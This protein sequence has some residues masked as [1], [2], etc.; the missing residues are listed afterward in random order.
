MSRVP[1]PGCTVLEGQPHRPGCPQHPG[2]YTG[3][4]RPLIDKVVALIREHIA[5]KHLCAELAR[6][7]IEL[8]A[9]V[10]RL[11]I[12]N[13][14]LRAATRP[15]TI[16]PWSPKIDWGNQWVN[17]CETGPWDYSNV[18][19]ETGPDSSSVATPPGN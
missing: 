18:R 9:K 6:K 11:E 19:C 1:C 8:E 7:V 12:E 16:G 14:R 5:E 4:D 15:S 17:R 2:I 13:S 3:V 10:A